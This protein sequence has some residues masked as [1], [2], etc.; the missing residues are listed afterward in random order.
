MV[1]ADTSFLSYISILEE[2][3]KREMEVYSVIAHCGPVSNKQIAKQLEL[4]INCVTGRTNKLVEKGTIKME[5]SQICKITGR[6]EKTWGV[7]RNL[8]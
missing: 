7:V 8:E 5:G 6:A 3:G 2:L 4:P 1:V